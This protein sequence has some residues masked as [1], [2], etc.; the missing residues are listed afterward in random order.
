MADRTAPSRA[1]S[2][3]NTS[4][5]QQDLSMLF[6]TLHSHLMPPLGSA[7][8]QLLLASI[9]ELRSAFCQDLSNDVNCMY[10]TKQLH[11]ALMAWMRIADFITTCTDIV[12]GATQYIGP[13]S[14][15]KCLQFMPHLAW[16]AE[17]VARALPEPASKTLASLGQCR[18]QISAD[19]HQF[20]HFGQC[21]CDTR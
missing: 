2:R 12:T 11:Q 13:G 14:G 9:A 4:L 18:Q 7:V 16:H 17:P 5:H 3:Y 1:K 19:C 21:V 6:C 10:S 15:N 20:F 8:K